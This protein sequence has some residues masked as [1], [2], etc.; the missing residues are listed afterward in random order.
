[1]ADVQ[2]GCRGELG[3]SFGW[4]HDAVEL[5]DVSRCRCLVRNNGIQ[6]DLSTYLCPDGSSRNQSTEVTR[7]QCLVV[8][9]ALALL[10]ERWLTIDQVA[11]SRELTNGQINAVE[12][13]RQ[14][15]ESSRNTPSARP[16][17][18]SPLGDRSTL[19]VR[20][21]GRFQTAGKAREV[22]EVVGHVLGRDLHVV[23]GPRGQR[24]VTWC[25]ALGAQGGDVAF[26]PGLVTGR[27]GAVDEEDR[28][29]GGC[30][31]ASGA[32]QCCGEGVCVYGEGCISCKD[33]RG[34]SSASYRSCGGDGDE[35][36]GGERA[37]LERV[38]DMRGLGRVSELKRWS[39]SEV[40]A[41]IVLE[42]SNWH[43]KVVCE[44]K[45]R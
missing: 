33:V 23:H 22:M 16:E 19:A 14:R 13:R 25:V 20:D 45:T 37:H 40:I 5:V 1:L 17:L 2:D 27:G 29:C 34:S 35:E 6:G 39:W 41:T 7:V 21:D 31:V 36:R 10:P 28:G 32:G 11:D 38:I 26:A 30:W 8:V 4:G 44:V 15:N 24:H 42:R 3:V 9:R 18:Q 43:E 12:V